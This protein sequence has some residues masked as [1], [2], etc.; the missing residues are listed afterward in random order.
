MRIDETVL[1][2]YALGVLS[3]AESASVDAALA[4]ST[5]IRK[6]LYEIQ[7]TLTK[8]A[9][10]ECTLQ[11]DPRLRERVLASIEP[12][13]RFE[14]FTERFAELFDLSKKEATR[15]LGKIDQTQAAG[16]TSTVFPGVKIL[17]FPGG[18][19]VASA[20]CG[21]ISIKPNTLFPRHR[22]RDEERVLVLQGRARENSGRL[23]Q[24][25]DLLISGPGSEHA[26]VTLDAG[27]CI[28]AVLLKKDNRWLILP[29]LLDRILGKYRFPDGGHEI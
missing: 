22:H 17:K 21:L 29:S 9:L 14:G 7:E 2:Q 10:S 1:I 12:G 28:L 11:P 16:W 25:G 26:F 19:R 5:E 13:T 24:P 27:P 4:A 8:M 18:P 23:F 20:T 15:L 3:A 6:Q